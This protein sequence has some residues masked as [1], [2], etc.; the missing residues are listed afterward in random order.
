MI[1]S[2]LKIAFR[3]I[4]RQKGYSIINITGLS[5]G[6]ASCIL[7]LLWV[8]HELSY[9]RF[10][11][12][13]DNLYRVISS[14]LVEVRETKAVD[15][16]SPVGS[17]LVELF[18]EINNFTRVQSGW[19][20]W[21]FD[22]QGK[23]F[24]NERLACADPSF[25]QIF[26]FPFIKGNPQ[27]AL[28]ERHSM[29]LT[30][31]LAKKIFGD[32]EPMGKIIKHNDTDMMVTGVIEDIPENSHIQFDY[33]FPVIN[34][35]DWRESDLESW[36]YMQ[37]ATYVNIEQAANLNLINKKIQKLIKKYDPESKISLSLQPLSE[38]HLY[39]SDINS[40]NI[41]YPNP[42][43]ITYIYIFSLI[44]FSILLLACI[45]YMNLSTARSLIR[46]KEIGVRKVSGAHRKDLIFQFFSE[47]LVLSLFSYVTAIF[48]VELFLPAFNSLSGKNLDYHIFENTQIFIG[49]ILILL[50]TGFIAGSYPAFYLSTLNPMKTIHRFQSTTS[51]RPG[52]LR[53]VLVIIQFTVT[54]ILIFCTIVYYQQ[55]NFIQNKDLGFEH[56]NIIYFASY[57]EYRSNYDAARTELLQNPEILNVCRAF[58]PGRYGGSSDVD[59]E[60]K[61]PSTDIKFFTEFVDYDY[62]ETFKMSM[63]KGRFYSKEHSTDPENYVLNQAA[64]RAMGMQNPIGEKFVYNGRA[65]IIIGVINDFIGGSLHHVIRP[66][67]FEFGAGGFFTC[68]RHSAGKTAEMISF[69]EQK[70]N[71]FVPGQPFQYRLLNESIDNYYKTER[72]VINI[73]QIFT[74]L[75]IIIASLGLYGLAAFMADRRTKEIGIRKVLGAKISALLVLFSKEFSQLVVYA[76][77]IAWPVAWYFMSDW[78]DGFAYRVDLN[79]WTFLSTGIVALSIALF[80]I[81]FQAIRAARKNP[82]ESLRYE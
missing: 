7:I 72:R 41:V 74:V 10:H 58:P 42:G 70:W 1:Y 12:N 6:I 44:A 35:T 59:W 46:A 4:I 68:I 18:P 26:K 24:I 50:L 36:E 25:F 33:I 45:N 73:V 40:W 39:S 52:H 17:A 63:N 19:T 53:R 79:I 82:V 21:N 5:V 48:L 22:Y 30:E 81:S 57:G 23:T 65:G 29:V 15:S 71:K 61:D 62:L 3:N 20:G 31:S 75:A 9:D 13:F 16:P 56:D 37:F 54:I 80:T 14:D 34:M 76:T 2:Y 38:I 51:K 11:P 69:L 77:V 47:T 66:K 32:A 67:V 49:T 28:K 78:L 43:N 60:G 27:T 55:L 64:I 8:Q